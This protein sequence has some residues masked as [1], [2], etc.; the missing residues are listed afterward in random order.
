M[1]KIMTSQGDMHA[2]EIIDSLTFS[3]YCANRGYGMQPDGFRRLGF[4]NVDAMEARYQ[5]QRRGDL[6]PQQGKLA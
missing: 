6:H 1:D 3:S 2:E 5:A 4:E